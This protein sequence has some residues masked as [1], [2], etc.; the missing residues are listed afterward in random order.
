MT[1]DNTMLTAPG[2]RPICLRINGSRTSSV[3]GPHSGPSYRRDRTGASSVNTVQ[4][5]Y[6]I[7][8]SV[9]KNVLSTHL[10]TAHGKKP[11]WLQEQADDLH[12]AHAVEHAFNRVDHA[13]TE[14][15]GWPVD[16]PRPSRT[17]ADGS[18]RT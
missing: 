14:G 12:S 9:P 4:A 3:T 8:P 10:Q 2:H 16:R 11:S 7:H 17:T 5:M 6:A 18:V 13:L 1:P 15:F